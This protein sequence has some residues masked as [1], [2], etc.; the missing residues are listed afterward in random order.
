M[1]NL[2]LYQKPRASRMASF[3][4]VYLDWCVRVVGL[5]S[6]HVRW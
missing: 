4:V 6:T 5:L 3:A 2:P 1:C